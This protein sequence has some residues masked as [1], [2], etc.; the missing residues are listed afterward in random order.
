MPDPTNPA[1]VPASWLSAPTQE[2]PAAYRRAVARKIK[3]DRHQKVL[4]MANEVEDLCRREPWIAGEGILESLKPTWWSKVAIVAGYSGHTPSPTT[5]AAV[6]EKVRADLAEPY[7]AKGRGPSIEGGTVP[8]PL[9]KAESLDLCDP[10]PPCS[11]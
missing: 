7:R 4:A 6:I 5:I 1:D 8:K 11:A 2:K 9:T 10:C 3:N